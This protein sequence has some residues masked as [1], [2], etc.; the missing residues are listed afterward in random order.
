MPFGLALGLVATGDRFRDA[1]EAVV[2]P[3]CVLGQPVRPSAKRLLR[4]P[5]RRAASTADCR[6]SASTGSA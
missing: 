4:S 6:A 5:A 1:A 2:V 3:L